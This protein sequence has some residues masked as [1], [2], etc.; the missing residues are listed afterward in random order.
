M[1]A[2]APSPWQGRHG[3]LLIAEIGG[4]HEGD[5]EAALHMTD[6]AIASGADV[7]K[8]QIYSGDTLVSPVESPDRHRHFQRFELTREQHLQ[9]ARRIIE[10]GCIYNASVWDLEAL[11]WLD[12]HLTFYKV[13]SGDL[14]AY[15]LLVG[16]A[17]RGKPILLST[18]L[19]TLDEV[20]DAVRLIRATNPAYARPE[21]LALL[22]CTSMYPTA[23]EEVNLR[24]MDALAQ[25]T[26][27]PVGYS[28]H[29][30]DELALLAAVA[31]G[32]RVLEFHFTD[33]RDGQ[34]FR[35]HAL[36]LMAD[37]VGA[38]AGKIGRLRTLL[39]SPGKAPTPG[40]CDSGHV[41]SFRRAVYS[42]RA[43]K[44]G[45]RLQRE[46]LV[47]LRPNH[48]IDAR[49]F[50]A[51]VGAVVTRD[52]PAFGALQIEGA[53]PDATGCTTGDSRAPH[54]HAAQP[55]PLPPGAAWPPVAQTPPQ[56]YCQLAEGGMADAALAR[57]RAACLLAVQRTGG[58]QRGS[59]KPFAC[60]LIG[61]ASLVA[62]AVPHDDTLVIAA[63]LHALYQERVSGAD[64]RESQR[65]AMRAAW[66]DEVEAL[67][68]AYQCAGLPQPDLARTGPEALTP[69][70]RRV[71][72]LQLADQLEDGL[73]G[74]PWWH[75][76]PDDAGTEPGSAQ[77]R[78]NRFVALA[79][80]FEQAPALGAPGLLGRHRALYAQW[81]QQRWPASL[82]SGHY[83]SFRAE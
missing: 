63:L 13:G 82:R 14:T 78:V 56:L 75:G 80:L 3:P 20:V 22:Q 7:V 62:E 11:E 39:G 8:F 59:G 55:N 10:A 12:P 28:H 70:A 27:C 44:A 69:L 26:G 46:D 47:V 32:A 1:S 72:L 52:T 18:G 19:S 57:I 45:E 24:A 40:E 67:L 77:D 53:L 41:Q 48:G 61:V 29:T 4:N 71:R 43:L 83:S 49:D 73:D 37:E 36:S 9:L 54:R 74:G 25:A 58:L 35:D 34:D 23:P 51:V 65:Q 38:L 30:S 5:F 31:R 81:P 2:P 76:S 68:H 42:R 21:M 64:A 66:G 15:P 79:A 60:H 33:R 50:D 17:R 6:L 16:L